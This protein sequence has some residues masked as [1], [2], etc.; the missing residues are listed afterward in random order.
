MKIAPTATTALGLGGNILTLNGGGLLVTGSST[1]TI[2]NG[3]LTAGGYGIGGNDLIVQQYSSAPL[4][5]SAAIVDNGGSYITAFT[6]AGPGTT[7]F[8]A[9]GTNTYSGGTTIGGGTLVVPTTALLPN[10]NSAG[11]VVVSN[12]ATLQINVGGPNDWT[13]ANVIGVSSLLS[14]NAANFAS[15]STLALDTTNGNC[16]MSSAGTLTGAYNLAKVGANT[17]IVPPSNTYTGNT[18]LNGGILAM[19]ISGSNQSPLGSGGTLYLNGGTLSAFD[20]Y[21]DG[22]GHSYYPSSANPFQINGNGDVGFGDALN[23]YA[24]SLSGRGTITG[25]GSTITVASVVTSSGAAGSVSLGVLSDNGYGFTKDGPGSLSL[26]YVAGAS[27][28]T[29]ITGPITVSNGTLT[30]GGG[31]ISGYYTI[32]MPSA[33]NLYN[34]ATLALGVSN[35][36]MY[37]PVHLNGNSNISGNNFTDA[38]GTGI[39]SALV[40]KHLDGTSTANCDL[41]TFFNPGNILGGITGAGSSGSPYLSMVVGYGEDSSAS[42]TCASTFVQSDPTYNP[43]TL[44]KVG[45]GS[46]T[47]SGQSTFSG[48]SVATYTY[49]TGTMATWNAGYAGPNYGVYISNITG[50]IGSFTGRVSV[51]D[52][53]GTL[54]AGASTV[55]SPG[56]ITSGPFGTGTVVLWTNYNGTA[57]NTPTL[58]SAGTQTIANPLLLIGGTTSGTTSATGTITLGDASSNALNLSGAVT[59]AGFYDV[60]RGSATVPSFM[61]VAMTLNV[62]GN[63]VTISGNIGEATG[64]TGSGLIKAGPGTLTLTGNL[65]YTGRTVIQAG[66]LKA[67]GLGGA[68]LVGSGNGLDIQGGRAVWDFTGTGY[69]PATVDGLVNPIM[70]NAFGQGWALNGLNP[71]IGLT[72]ADATHGLGWTDTVVGGENLLTVMYTLYGDTNLDGTVNGGDLNTVLSNF[73]KTGMTWAQGDFD[74]NGT[75]NGGDLNTVLS[76]FNQHLSVTGAVPEPSS[77]L[78]LAAGLTGLLAYAWRKRK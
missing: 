19:S 59:L 60:V 47:L 10:Y 54:A 39:N 38:I 25:S 2:S 16:D 66:T 44:V 40:I 43:G 68:N 41:S 69:S 37:S 15:G 67:V 11:K 36:V 35:A 33:V 3:T 14:G 48:A 70:Q 26:G 12:A 75:V 28:S 55:G 74:Y 4:T 57:G 32:G 9:G 71:Y 18:I 45:N 58:T 34:S 24:F 72:T 56:S 49:A 50:K 21:D 53:Q 65:N 62:P 8:V 5:I 27:S 7:L 63:G 64:A 61:P 30:T 13:A 46:W 42:G 17:L 1:V 77:L 73:N 76:N 23:N 6:K 51:L 31:G 52:W 78:L 20:Y 22:H 29:A